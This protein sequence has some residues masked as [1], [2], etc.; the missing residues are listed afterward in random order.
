MAVFNRDKDGSIIQHESNGSTIKLKVNKSSGQMEFSETPKSEIVGEDTQNS[1][2]DPLELIKP[3]KFDIRNFHKEFQDNS[4]KVLYKL[5][6]I[7]SNDQPLKKGGMGIGYRCDAIILA[8]R[9]LFTIQENTLFDIISAYMSSRPDDETYCIYPKDVLKYLPYTDTTYVYKIFSEATDTLSNKPLLFDITDDN[10]KSRRVKVPWYT[11]F[12]YVRKAEDCENAYISFTPSPLFKALMISST[13]THGA[14]FSVFVS[15]QIQSKYV[16]NL[17]YV[18]ES[19]KN[20]TEY[21][22]A[23]P[24]IV[25][26]S[27]NE[28]QSLIGYPASYR[29]TDIRRF[30]LEPAVE[31]INKLEGVDFTFSFTLKKTK[32]KFTHVIFKITQIIEPKEPKKLEDRSST[33]NMQ[34]MNSDTV[35][36]DEKYPDNVK[37]KKNVTAKEDELILT[38]LEANG[39]TKSECKMVLSKYH[40]FNRNITF[41]SQALTN[42]ISSRKIRSKAAVLAYIM[43]NGLGTEPNSDKSKGKGFNN[44]EQR[45]YDYTELEKVLLGLQNND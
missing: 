38:M 30:I 27:F 39:L 15:S 36:E 1:Q 13:I 4:E 17:F 16:R 29:T 8:N 2:D 6:S 12:T 32:T 3:G 33:T 44:F 5:L 43:E 34:N 11:I 21:V 7:Q 37:E 45:D 20:R 26:L 10:G 42:V 25:T 19:M 18:L 28:L 40:K 31:D 9:Q 23:V 24:G 14:H 35:T 22:G 41:F